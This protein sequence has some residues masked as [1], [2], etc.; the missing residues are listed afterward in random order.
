D[1]VGASINPHLGECCSVTCRLSPIMKSA[2]LFFTFVILTS[3]AVV[4]QDE[5]SKCC[6][7]TYDVSV[8]L[9]K[10]QKK[11]DAEL[12][13]TYAE[14]LEE[15]KDSSKDAA[16]LKDAERKW[17]EYRDAACKAEYG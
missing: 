13:K 17:I 6:C 3:S 5:E 2:I 14:A 9:G 11:L 4:A 8:C 1:H 15:L 12:N 7:T 10:I 16:N